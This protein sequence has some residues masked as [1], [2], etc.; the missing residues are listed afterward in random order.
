[1]SFRWKIA[2]LNIL[3]IIL[4]FGVVG[5]AKAQNLTIFVDTWPPY[6]FEEDDKIVGICTELIEAS[7]QKANVQYK[8]VVYPFKRAL[9]TVQKTPNTMFF[10]VAR[11]PQREDMFAWIGPLHSRKV[12]L[13]KLKDRTDIQFNDIEDIKKY[14]TGVLLGGSVETLLI[15][16]GFHKGNYH[17]IH[18]SSQLLKMLLEKRLDLIPGD[19]LDLAYQIKSLGHKYSEL[20]IVYLLSEEGGYY[21]VANK[22]TSDEIIVK[23]QKALEL[24]LATGTKDRI[25]Q[26]Y[27]E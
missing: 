23:I 10:T 4:L 3:I 20:E 1:M 17:S 11:I 15:A 22:D 2:S 19:P 6:N 7:L 9:I 18:K 13:F 12:S 5:G 21:M 16:K 8:L 24:I 25:L 26:K 27:M 14:R